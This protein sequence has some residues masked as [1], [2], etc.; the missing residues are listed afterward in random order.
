MP[1][2]V[3]PV[4]LLGLII[5]SVLSIGVL[6][7]ARSGGGGSASDALAAAESQLGK[8][9]VMSTDGP[10]TF[11]CVG[12]MRYALRTAGVDSDAPWVP[13]EYL[14]RY[15]PVAPGDLQP[16]DIVIYPGWATMYAG[17]GQLINANEMEGFVTH[18]SMDVAGEPLG[19]VR[20]YGGQ[21]LA[22]Q[23]VPLTQPAPAVDPATDPMA[24]EQ[25]PVDEQQLPVVDE[26]LPVADPALAVDPAPVTDPMPVT[27]PITDPALAVEQPLPGT[28]PMAPAQF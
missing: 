18:T 24:A 21:P 13:E 20:P 4:V 3:N 27:D 15:A 22:E 16:G 23:L 10:D 7:S 1:V 25:L 26:Q 12:L 11:S 28:D 14:S 17:N 9:F 19:I 8:P 6:A 2:R 5:V